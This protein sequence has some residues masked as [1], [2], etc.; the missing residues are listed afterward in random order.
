MTF[1]SQQG[2]IAS[3]TKFTPHQIV[4]LEVSGDRLYAEV[5]QMAEKRQTC[6]V[7]PILL[8][9]AYQENVFAETTSQWQD[10]RHCSDL[11]CPAQLL[12]LAL[13]TEIIPFLGQLQPAHSHL[14]G[15]PAGQQKLHQF[16]GKLWQA[17]SSTF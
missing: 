15:N 1:P 4:Y 5:V 13:D 6:W 10:L 3:A 11:L 14:Q 2:N 9:L 16:I 17:H 8:V 12:Q 7:R